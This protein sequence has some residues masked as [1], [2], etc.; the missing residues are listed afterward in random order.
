MGRPAPGAAAQPAR[1]D[2]KPAAAGKRKREDR[3]VKA[4]GKEH[5]GEAADTIVTRKRKRGVTEGEEEAPATSDAAGAAKVTRKR[6][7]DEDSTATEPGASS[8]SAVAPE[9]A[10]APKAKLTRRQRRRLREAATA[11]AAAAAAA[12]AVAGSKSEDGETVDTSSPGAKS[13]SSHSVPAD[14]TSKAAKVAGAKATGAKADGAKVPGAKVAKTDAT[15]AETASGKVEAST[16]RRAKLSATPGKRYFA[17]KVFCVTSKGSEDTEVAG[18]EPKPRSGQQQHTYDTISELITSAG[19][20]VTGICHRRVF[21][22]VAT[23]RASLRRTQRVRKALKFGIPIV[24]PDF[25]R[26]C[27]AQGKC[28]PTAPFELEVPE[29]SAIELITKVLAKNEGKVMET[30]A[31][32]RSKRSAREESVPQSV[33]IDLGCCCSCHADGAPHCSWCEVHH[34]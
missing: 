15:S 25:L 18:A 33:V 22:L 30:A 9:G 29:A 1:E 2:A 20:S 19:G 10:V 6:K 5:E 7:A 16:T 14:F 27:V 26:E 24:S 3:V 34:T 23:E 31:K 4:E 32:K 21:A 12:A 28:V 8:S 17:D 11:A 13:L